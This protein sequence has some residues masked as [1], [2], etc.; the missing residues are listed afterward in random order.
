MKYKIQ[1]LQLFLNEITFFVLFY[2]PFT[3]EFFE[4]RNVLRLSHGAQHITALPRQT[5]RW[6]RI[7]NSMYVGTDIRRPWMSSEKSLAEICRHDF[8]LP[9]KLPYAKC[10]AHAIHKTISK[11]PSRSTINDLCVHKDLFCSYRRNSIDLVSVRPAFVVL[12]LS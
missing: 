2:R 5:R 7:Y 11:S 1:A 10:A 9:K 3:V 6:Y 12:Y 4:T 8:T